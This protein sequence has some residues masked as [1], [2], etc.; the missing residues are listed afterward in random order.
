MVNDN[1]LTDQ[2]YGLI[3]KITRREGKRGGSGG[4]VQG[5]HTPPP[6]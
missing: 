3:R 5:V 1:Y 6:P 2:G 4:R